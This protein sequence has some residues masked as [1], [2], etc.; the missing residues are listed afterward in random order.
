M[1]R[2]LFSVSNV[3]HPTDIFVYIVMISFR[4]GLVEVLL[5]IFIP[6]IVILISLCFNVQ[7]SLS[8]IIYFTLK[9]EIRSVQLITVRTVIV[10]LLIT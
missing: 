6:A 3:F 4:L 9:Y 5:N 7:I 2:E 8:Y 1:V 10:R